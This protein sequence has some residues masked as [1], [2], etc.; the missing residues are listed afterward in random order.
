MGRRRRGHGGGHDRL[1]DRAHA[2]SV[3]G[4]ADY[5]ALTFVVALVLFPTVMGVAILRYR[6]YDIDVV[7]RRT[8]VYA[9]LVAVL[10]LFYLGGIAILG[11]VFRSATG[12]SG[13]LAVTLSTLS[14]A[15]GFQPL[16]RRIQHTIDHRF[17]RRAYDA[18]AAVRAFTGRL[19]EQIDLDV[20][21]RELVG[22]V[23]DTVAPRHASLWLRPSDH[24]A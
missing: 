9:C 7:I 22:V 8:L 1:L 17:A 16:R 15:V 18:E 13:T 23:D 2:L 5:S 12:A 24:D 10:A 4:V 21:S 6:L 3:A 20:L 19:R 11:A 14:V